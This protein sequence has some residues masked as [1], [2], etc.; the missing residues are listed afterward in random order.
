MKRIFALST[1]LALG[2]VGTAGA[3]PRGTFK[4]TG[5]GPQTG[6]TWT[7]P[8][9]A[10]VSHVIYLNNC[11]PSGC[12]LSAGYDNS[13]TNTSSIPNTSSTVAAYSGSQTNWDALVNCVKQVYSPFDVQI[14]TTRPT[15]GSYHM[16]VV[17]GTPGQVGMGNGVLGVSPFTCGY[18]NNSIS[19]TFANLEPSNIPELCWTVAQETAHSWGLDHKY[20]NRDPM[21]YLSGGPSIKQFQNEAGSCGEYS[22]RSCNCSYPSTGT[23]KMNSYAVIL[24]VFGSSAPDTVPPTVKITAP[25]ELAQVMPGFK[26]TA[27]IA[28]DR[29]IDK[30][31]FRLDGVLVSTV[32]E[33]PWQWTAPST[34]SQ[35]KHK[36]EIAATDRGGNTTKDMHNVQYGTVCATANDCDAAGN[37]CLDGHC[38]VGPSMP[39]GLGTNCTGN[40]DCASMQCG[41]NGTTGYCVESCDLTADACPDGFACTDT[42]GGAGVCWPDK[43]SGGCE[44]GY[45]SGNGAWLLGL[46]LVGALV[47]RRR[48]R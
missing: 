39:G 40:S 27:D 34:L 29:I 38:V 15:S 23:A 9:Q 5:D 45:D 2:M 10:A 18:I 48:R 28:D 41:M 30:A 21:T 13:T 35:G 1:V 14:V 4:W 22:A 8:P 37:V 42:G 32:N 6:A 44:S 24:G 43:K 16:A 26:V 31:E 17:G 7:P 47:I 11:Q 36:I 46:G 33:E 19:F 12:N 3:E 25:A 20:D